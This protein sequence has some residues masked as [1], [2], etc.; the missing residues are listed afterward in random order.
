MMIKGCVVLVNF[1]VFL[2][3]YKVFFTL[4][5]FIPNTLHSKTSLW[6]IKTKFNFEGKA[7][8]GKLALDKFSKF[9]SYGVWGQKFAILTVL[10]QKYVSCMA[11]VFPPICRT[12]HFEIHLKY[13]GTR[14]CII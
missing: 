12:I 5:V 8:S 14:R 4:F 10:F 7:F 3:Q 11:K 1:A 9:S 6:S 2:F 13:R